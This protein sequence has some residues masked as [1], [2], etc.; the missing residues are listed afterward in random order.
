M[1]ATIILVD[2]QSREYTDE[3]LVGKIVLA[4]VQSR[5]Y[6]DKSRIPNSELKLRKKYL[7]TQ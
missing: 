5:E 4:S 2:M 1:E 6:T 3:S 7:C